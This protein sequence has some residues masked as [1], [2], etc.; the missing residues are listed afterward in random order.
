MCPICKTQEESVLHLL[1]RC[2]WV[3]PIWF[4]GMLGL[5]RVGEGVSSF[6]QWLSDLII[7]TPNLQDRSRLLFVIAFSCWY[8]WK[9]RCPF[10]PLPTIPRSGSSL[11]PPICSLHKS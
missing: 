9:A 7:Q 11:V 6:H 10:V 1:L 4:G 5:R 8:I 3:E 2:P